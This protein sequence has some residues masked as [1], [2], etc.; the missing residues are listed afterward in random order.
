MAYAEKTSVGP[1]QIITLNQLQS[2]CGYK[3]SPESGREQYSYSCSHP[4]NPERCETYDGQ[5]MGCLCPIADC[6]DDDE[7]IACPYYE[8]DKRMMVL[9]E[10]NEAQRTGKL[11]PLLPHVG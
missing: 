9:T 1:G 3:T 8:G 4:R 10:I 2:V 6:I 11:P 5:C 7:D